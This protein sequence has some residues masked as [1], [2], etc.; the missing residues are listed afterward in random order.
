MMC[1]DSDDEAWE[2]EGMLTA[3]LEVECAVETSADDSEEEETDEVNAAGKVE[4]DT[5]MNAMLA[6]KGLP[7][8]VCESCSDDEH[9]D[10]MD[11]S[12]DTADVLTKKILR[13]GMMFKL[14]RDGGKESWTTRFCA[15][16]DDEVVKGSTYN[17]RCAVEVEGHCATVMQ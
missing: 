17:G 13:A 14:E 12:V 3:A 5:E 1:G 10:G 8:L 16:G 6:E 2:Q 7:E 9:G 11:R 4:E 15:K